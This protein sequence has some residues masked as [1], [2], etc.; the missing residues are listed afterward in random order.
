LAH[1]APRFISPVISEACN[2]SRRIASRK[3]GI[4]FG[5]TAPELPPMFEVLTDLPL[6]EPWEIRTRKRR[7]RKSPAPGAL[8]DV[9]SAAVRLNITTEQ[10][11]GF[12]AAGA[13][14]YV[15]V[16]LGEVRPRYRFSDADLQ[17]F[18][19]NKRRSQE[20]PSCPFTKAKSRKAFSGSTSGS[21]VVGFMA[22][23]A[24]RLAKKLKR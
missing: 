14:R 15:N 12:V 24:A 19:T 7:K 23:R 2:G 18:E 5:A 8:H 22:A 4:M 10:L 6:H 21:T 1:D 11:R 16:G 13:L 9:R 17:E 20:M 3:I